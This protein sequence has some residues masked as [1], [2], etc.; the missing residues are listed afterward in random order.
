M[1]SCTPSEEETLSVLNDYRSLLSLA[2]ERPDPDLMRRVTSDKEFMRIRQYIE[3][4]LSDSVILS[5]KLIESDLAEFSDHG[6]GSRH[7]ISNEKWIVR[8][9]DRE[10]KEV[11]AD[12]IIYNFRTYYEFKERDKA[13]IVDWV[14]IISSVD[15][16]KNTD[17]PHLWVYHSSENIVR[18]K[19]LAYVTTLAQA[20]EHSKP[21]L[22]AG[23]SDQKQYNDVRQYIHYLRKMNKKMKAEVMEFAITSVH[24]IKEDMASVTTIEK[25]EYQYIDYE[26][27]K[28][29]SDEYYAYY[30]NEYRIRNIGGIWAV[31]SVIEKRKESN[32]K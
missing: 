13:L 24:F 26:S 2:C 9:L 25:W 27:G 15:E 30:E 17:F 23:I 8:L 4:L 11:I 7:I 3:K 6:D 1:I 10:T 29:V 20:L 5:L 28:P 12:D 14:K 21:E 16:Y 31:A 32:E 22:M 18:D 19:A